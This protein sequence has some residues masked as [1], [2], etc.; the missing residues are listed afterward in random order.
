VRVPVTRFAVRSVSSG[1]RVAHSVRQ[2]MIG[3]LLAT[4]F[5]AVAP[6]VIAGAD[7]V[8]TVS[9]QVQATEAQVNADA[10]RI[11]EFTVAYD[12]ASS[13]A[14]ALAEKVRGTTAQLTTLHNQI[15]GIEATIRNEAVL[16]YTGQVSG[17]PELATANPTQIGVGQEY[18]RSTAGNFSNTLDALNVQ[19]EKVT[20]VQT[21]L[22]DEE[23][24][25]QHQLAEAAGVRQQALDQAVAAQQL[26]SRA[27]AELVSTQRGD[28][29]PARA[30]ATTSAKAAAAPQGAPVGNSLE[31]T[32][33]S[34]L[35]P[36]P[37]IAPAAR[38]PTYVSTP[39]TSSPTTAAAPSAA[40]TVSAPT[41]PPAPTRVSAPTI[42]SAPSTAA[43]AI[44]AAPTRPTTAV[45]APSS[46][47]GG[48]SNGMLARLRQCESGG[49]YRENSGDG[50]YGAYQLSPATWSLL[51]VPGRPD[52]SPPA[53]QDQAALTL[54]ARGG[55]G[56]WPTCNALL[57]L[58]G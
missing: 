6:G 55:W 24:V 23:R 13:Q 35:S 33:V 46:G 9:A 16:A 10:A 41:T 54:V 17:S 51:G 43:P 5:L 1:P 14:A 18:L 49:N 12:Q 34:A 42:R 7:P 56:Q 31:Q 47:G 38:T 50:F 3:S 30:Q 8:G 2:A 20:T 53:V 36:S 45:S 39:T 26:L 29:R 57:G 32:V 21:T 28:A 37:T 52:Q 40:R 22:R 11:H 27:Q 15:A 19:Q 48:S 58:G 44:T 25:Q 4:V